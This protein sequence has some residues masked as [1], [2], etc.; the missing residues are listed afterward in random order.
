MAVK[1]I[2]IEIGGDTKG[3]KKA[4]S[5][6]NKETNTTQ[7]EL[8]AV[9]KALKLNPNNIDL[10]RQRQELLTKQITTTE[11]KVN[12]LKQAKA[13]ADS[14][15]VDGTEINQEQYRLLVREIS[16]AESNLVELKNTSEITEDA[17]EKVADDGSI[18]FKEL[19]KQIGNADD[20][21]EK[22]AKGGFTVMK[23][24]LS[25]LVSQGINMAV[26]GLKNLA[27]KFT[28]LGL[29][30]DD[31]NTL[32][33]Q[34]GFSTAELQ[35]MEYAADVI[36]VSVDDIVKSGQKMKKNM[37][38]N[39]EDTQAAFSRLGVSVIDSNG[40]LRDSNTVFYE[41]LDGLSKVA[42][43]TERDTLAML[44]FGKSAD[45]LA[46]IVDD[47]GAALRQLGEE[48]ENVGAVLSQDTLDSANEF[49][50]AMDRVKSTATGAFAQVGAGIANELAPQL[51]AFVTQ[52]QEWMK[53]EE[54]QIFLQNIADGIASIISVLAIVVNFIVSNADIIIPI[55]S[56]IAAAILAWNVAQ[57]ILNLTMLASPITWIILAIAALIAII[58]ALVMNW[59]TVS[60]T[61]SNVWDTVCNALGNAW[62]WIRSLFKSG[63]NFL[64]DILNGILGAVEWI[65]NHIIS[66][67]N[68][69]ISMINKLI[70][71]ISDLL[72]YIGLSFE[73]RIPSVSEVNIPRVQHL[74][75][76]G[77]LDEG[78]S[79]VVGDKGAELLTVQGGK[80]QV[81]PLNS[82]RAN[83][84]ENEKL[85]V[86]INE[87]N[88]YDTEVDTNLLADKVARKIDIKARRVAKANGG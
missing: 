1:G 44:I 38:S 83:S 78:A 34:S 64:I 27:G 57:A 70:G 11:D 68:S 60:E 35:K 48:A 66:A 71:G 26:N 36:D 88:N 23:G 79:A 67:I 62:E 32:S 14:D 59:E 21:A 75:K 53:S 24:A 86:N 12:A 13:K 47:G 54:G 82:M 22:S 72:D 37:I 87:F 18:E 17:I 7:R 81:T 51:E 30:A 31:L 40:Q 84:V 55:F 77:V 3:L 9:E 65:I 69:G 73:W 46:G 63:V 42:N 43:E 19:S 16:N 45:S 8:K 49:N 5:D 56:A 10:L 6:V 41:V 50:D 61:V 39:S 58:V 25:N 76:G 4:L 2:T 20:S 52:F 85:Q 15:M 33:K 29:K 80:A 74:W 28:E